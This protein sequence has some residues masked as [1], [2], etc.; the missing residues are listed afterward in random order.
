MTVG[1]KFGGTSDLREDIRVG[2]LVAKHLRPPRQSLTMARVTA[3]RM[4]VFLLG[5]P[6]LTP[7]HSAR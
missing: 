5:L 4:K 7:T 2:I 1:S 6:D 3:V